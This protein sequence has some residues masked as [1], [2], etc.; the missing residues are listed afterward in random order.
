MGQRES[1]RGQ[2]QNYDLIK[3]S[4]ADGKY[5]ETG[6]ESISAM[7]Q[8]DMNIFKKRSVSASETRIDNR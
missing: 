2:T 7:S 6:I 3:I 4:E 5:S 8:C 1:F